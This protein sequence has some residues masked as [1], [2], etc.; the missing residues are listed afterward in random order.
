ML[1]HKKGASFRKLFLIIFTNWNRLIR[2]LNWS[3]L[4]GSTGAF[5]PTGNKEVLSY[6]ITIDM[7]VS[8]SMS[9]FD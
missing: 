8:L 4:M 2:L 6:L 3:L 9:R 7:V 1:L 5:H